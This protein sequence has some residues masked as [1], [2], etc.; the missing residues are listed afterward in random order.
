M[1]GVTA[2]EDIIEILNQPKVNTT[3]TSNILPP[4]ILSLNQVCF[5]YPERSPALNK[6]NLEF[7]SSGLYA[8]IGESGSGKSTLIDMILGFVQ[9]SSGEVIINNTPLKIANSEHW[10]KHCGWI[11][12]QA[13]IFYGSL[14][15]NVA[16]S[17]DYKG[18]LVIEALTKAGLANFIQTLEQGIESNVG[19]S[20]AGLS[21]GQAQ[22]LALARV[23]YH[24]PEILILDEPTSHL[25]QETEL[26]V[27][28][29]ISEYAKNHLVIVI[30][31]RL[32][33]VVDAKNIIV[34]E[35]GKVTESGTHQELL[36]L[37]GYYAQQVNL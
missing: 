17:D 23:F 33:T 1:A 6:V 35:Q 24:Q 37:N 15:F 32:Q 26:I 31:H 18:D 25:D 14:A 10:L 16:M 20:G 9:P 7:S 29:S 4:F 30:A 3:L 13:Q 2:A 12:Q 36:T 34:L 11:S 27:T 28:Q 8:V 19:E 5:S 22:R 21:G